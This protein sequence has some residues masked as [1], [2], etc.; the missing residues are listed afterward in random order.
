M[1]ASLNMP[2]VCRPT[3]VNRDCSN[4]SAVITPLLL[5]SLYICIAVFVG[6]Y[7]NER[8][9]K[10]SSSEEGRVMLNDATKTECLEAMRPEHVTFS[11]QVRNVPYIH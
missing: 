10:R 5:K 11:L 9:S 1:T 3:C 6:K 4:A 7:V 8:W 2:Y